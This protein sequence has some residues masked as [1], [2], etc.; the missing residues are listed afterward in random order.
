MLELISN[1]CLELIGNLPA[2]QTLIKM[3]WV[4]TADLYVKTNKE[5]KEGKRDR[6]REKQLCW[7]GKVQHRELL[8]WL[9]DASIIEGK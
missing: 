9:Q 5:K 4:E 6:K 2:A 3:V 1:V 7:M 8:L